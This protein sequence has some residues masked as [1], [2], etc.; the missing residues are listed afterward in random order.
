MGPIRFGAGLAIALL[1]GGVLHA[2]G[3]ATPRPA[4]FG[5]VLAAAPTVATPA[6]DRDAYARYERELRILLSPAQS[7]AAGTG[8]AAA[9]PFLAGSSSG[10]STQDCM[11]CH[12]L[13]QT[14]PVD[15]DYAQSAQRRPEFFRAPAEVVRRGVFLPDGQVKCITCHDPRSQWKYRLALPPGAAARLAVDVGNPATYERSRNTAL[16]APRPGSAVT[17]TPLCLSCHA[18]D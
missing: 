4:P 7:A 1:V 8:G 2:E 9:C 18:Y 6:Q 10:T 5:L 11:N 16:P 17:P 15:I 13:H 14:H 12:G 3:M